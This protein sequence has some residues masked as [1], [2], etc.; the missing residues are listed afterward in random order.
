M[1][2]DGIIHGERDKIDLHNPRESMGEIAKELIKIPLRRN[3][4][5]DLKKGLVALR[6]ILTGRNA[7]AYS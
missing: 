7:P 1:F 4:L 2:L 3:R 6:E 5:C